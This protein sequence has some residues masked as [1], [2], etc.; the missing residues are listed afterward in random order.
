[1]TGLLGAAIALMP[2]LGARRKT[3]LG[4]T[5]AVAGADSTTAAESGGLQ[6]S[7]VSLISSSLQRGEPPQP[8]YAPQNAP[9]ELAR[10]TWKPE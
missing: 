4:V 3:A 8:P 9:I 7:P 1:M 2:L 6:M 5:G 10:H